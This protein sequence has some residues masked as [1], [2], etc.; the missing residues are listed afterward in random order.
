MDGVRL[1]LRII[2]RVLKT[3]EEIL[4]NLNKRL[5]DINVKDPGNVRASQDI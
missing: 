4:A 2:G 3:V 5:E 1:N